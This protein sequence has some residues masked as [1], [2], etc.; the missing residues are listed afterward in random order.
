MTSS[1]QDFTLAAPMAPLRVGQ[2][3]PPP[4]PEAD[5]LG[6][7]FSGDG[8]VYFRIWIVNLLL[9]I[10][11]LGIYSAWGKVRSHQYL[12]GHTRFAG[13]SFGYHGKPLA[14]LKGRA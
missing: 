4:A 1:P 10:L 14:I 3:N 6:F 8:A 7:S 5:G 9:S 11:T 12:Y 13:S 2:P